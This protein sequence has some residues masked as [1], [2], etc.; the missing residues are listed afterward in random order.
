MLIKVRAGEGPRKVREERERL[1][2]RRTYR[3]V[4]REKRRKIK[5]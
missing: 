1:G 4:E 3:K 5:E 2:E